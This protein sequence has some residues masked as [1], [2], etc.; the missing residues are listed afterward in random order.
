MFG[1]CNNFR[2]HENT[3]YPNNKRYNVIENFIVCIYVCVRERERE[4]E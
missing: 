4:S 1:R 3:V 2:M